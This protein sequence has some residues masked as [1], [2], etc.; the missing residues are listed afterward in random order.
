MELKFYP[1]RS[2]SNSTR[3]YSPPPLS[4]NVSVVRTRPRL[5]PPWPPQQFSFNVSV[6][7]TTSDQMI[8]YPSLKKSFRTYYLSLRDLIINF[9]S[10]QSILATLDSVCSMQT[11]YL[12][13]IFYKSR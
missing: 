6:P 13:R 2:H 11:S 1:S 7:F 10:V 5:P 3:A 4:F 8:N 12:L 9:Y